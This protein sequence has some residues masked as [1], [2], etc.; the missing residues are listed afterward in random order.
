[1]RALRRRK[2][3]REAG[4]HF[5]FEKRKQKTSDSSASFFQ[6]RPKPNSQSF[7]VLFFK[8]E[9]LS[10]ACLAR[11]WTIQPTWAVKK[12]PKDFCDLG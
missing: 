12:A 7:L 10:A 11:R 1:V 8:K 3:D 2:A 4:K 6:E 5:F 9:P